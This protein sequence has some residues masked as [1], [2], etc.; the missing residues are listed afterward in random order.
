MI[1]GALHD[2][3]YL[4]GVPCMYECVYIIKN[5]KLVIKLKEETEKKNES[6]KHALKNIL[7]RHICH[8]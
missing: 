8:M 2:T 6:I 4:V 5:E 1:V 3:R 7:F